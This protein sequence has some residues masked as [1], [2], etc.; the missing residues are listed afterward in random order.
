MAKA[1]TKTKEQTIMTDRTPVTAR[2]VD[3]LKLIAASLTG[4]LMLTQEEAGD[5]VAQGLAVVD[6]TITENDTAAVSLTD[7]GKAAMNEVNTAAEGAGGQAAADAARARLQRAPVT[8]T[9]GLRKDIPAP[10]KKKGGK[11]GSK[12]P[13]D[14]MEV[15]ESFHIPATMENTNPLASVQSSITQARAKF[16]V[17]VVGSDGQP[18]MEAVKV[19]HYK[20]DAEGKYIKDADGKRI[21]ENETSEQRQ[22][23]QI[24]KDFTA[25]A[26]DKNDPDGAGARVWR[27][28]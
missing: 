7:A 3:L 9:Q 1:P 21:V 15:G 13:F 6:T 26:V 19:T 2:G 22:K 16:A 10:G 8:V 14:T 18:V 5:I 25:A 12:Y 28:A 24:T 27:I 20:K 4:Y 23:M 11:Q 17:G